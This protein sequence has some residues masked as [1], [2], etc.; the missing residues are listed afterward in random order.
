MPALPKKVLAT[1][2]TYWDGQQLTKLPGAYNTIFLFSAVP[3]G[4]PPGTTGVVMWSQNRIPDATFSVNIDAIR[5]AGRCV[6]LSIGGSNAYVRLD[7]TSRSNA[8]IASIEQIYSQIGG[9]DGID[10]DIE[11]GPMYSAQ[12]IY[13]AQ[14]LKAKYGPS[15]MVTMPPGPWDSAAASVCATMY[16]AGAIDLVM[17]Q[18]YELEGIS[19]ETAKISNL[20]N[21]IN[22][23]WLGV[24]GG[25][26][27]K[28]ALGY[29]ISSDVSETMTIASF[30]SAW[31]Q[32][33]KAHPTLRGVFCWESAGD[34]ATGYAF[35][36]AM[37]PLIGGGIAPQPAPKYQLYTVMTGD[38]LYRIGR[39]FSVRWQS[40][41]AL[42]N[43][44]SPYTLRVGA[45]LKIPVA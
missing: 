32:L 37:S 23:T 18:F 26:A 17:P 43:L 41:A 28:L 40:I 35:A 39:R 8:F 5:E 9:F 29:G 44:A 14:Q 1:Y 2:W 20:V 15:F 34:A 24:V 22:H 19:G 27:S 45:V 3:V 30:S 12:L 16:R 4:D 13:I 7:T 25:D 33:A 21:Y 38:T 10:L 36:N 6:I 42:N 11:E 31:T